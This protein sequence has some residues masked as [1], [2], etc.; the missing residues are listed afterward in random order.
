MRFVSS[1]VSSAGRR[2]AQGLRTEHRGSARP[3][4][5]PPVG[6]IG[7]AWLLAGHTARRGTPNGTHMEKEGERMT[8]PTNTIYYCP[9]CGAA[10]STVNDLERH[11]RQEHGTDARQLQDATGIA[12]IG[13]ASDEAAQYL[14]PACGAS[15]RG[16]FELDQ[17]RR[18]AH[19][20]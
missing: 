5:A 4:A 1:G 17:H 3:P 11:N 20:A 13:G 7:A 2:A 14:C 18:Q 16:Q 10:F 15:F 12:P 9:N 8:P 19:G 6:S